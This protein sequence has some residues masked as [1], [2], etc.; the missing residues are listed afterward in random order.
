MATLIQAGYY[1]KKYSDI[2][3]NFMLDNIVM[4]FNITGMYQMIQKRMES[5][6]H[7]LQKRLEAMEQSIQSS[8]RLIE[9]VVY[10][11]DV[12]AHVKSA[13][14]NYNTH[15]HI[16]AKDKGKG[17]HV[18]DV[19]EPTTKQSF[20][21]QTCTG[22]DENTDIVFNTS[23]DDI[24][25]N[26]I[27]NNDETNTL[28]TPKIRYAH[29]KNSSF[30]AKSWESGKMKVINIEEIKAKQLWTAKSSHTKVLNTLASNLLLHIYI[31]H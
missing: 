18:I 9:F 21:P 5:I 3:I 15:T 27:V 17:K 6:E 14:E 31:T 25:D 30:R 4:S 11:Q 26:D 28:I 10:S 1:L 7:M 23:D 12:S 16:V 19:D 13:D 8:L 29:D 2:V 20:L 22:L 24:Y